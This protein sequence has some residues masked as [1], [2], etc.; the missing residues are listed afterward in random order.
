MVALGVGGWA[1]GLFPSMG[2]RTGVWVAGA[3]LVLGGGGS[4]GRG[5]A[6]VPLN[7]AFAPTS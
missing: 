1:G 4:S 5:S 7:K 3:W 2:R 6:V